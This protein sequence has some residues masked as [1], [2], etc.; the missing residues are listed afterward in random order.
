MTKPEDPNR[1]VI[2]DTTLRD[3]EQSPG[4]SM[5]LA[6]KLKLAGALA[7]LGVDVIEAGFAAASPDDFEA[8]KAIADSIQGPAICALARCHDGDIDQAG[9]ALAG[10]ERRRIHV[11]IATSP[12]HREHKL[13]L[14]KEQIIARAV[15]GIRRA[16]TWTDDVE[17][18]AEDALRTEPEFLA[19]VVEAAID[20]GASTVNI[21][22]TVGY[23]SP[24]EM[25][26]RIRYLKLHV[27]NIDKAVISA[28]C[29]N[30]LGMAVANSL[31]AVAAGARQVEC[32]L[33]GIGE[34][35]GNAAL[36]EVVM[37]LKTRADHYGCHTGINSRRLL[38]ACRQLASVIGQA[39]PRNKAIVGDNAFAHESGI[40][41]H[42]MLQ[43]RDTYEIMDPAD[44]GLVRS[45][46]VLGKHSGRHALADRLRA[47]GHSPDAAR[48]DE[49]FARFKA[50]A[51][52]KRQIYDADIEALL[53]GQEQDQG[54]WQ[55]ARLQIQSGINPAMASAAVI[56]VGPD[57]RHHCEAATG[58]GPVDAAFKAIE[59]ATAITVDLQ[60]FSIRALTG[61]EDAQGEAH[62]Q[63]DID[64]RSYG[65][66]A[67]D[68][69]IIAASAQAFMTIINAIARRQPSLAKAG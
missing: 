4:C 29:H 21:P 20:A 17:F 33:T 58:D 22:D 19:Q 63:A 2:F 53:A 65:G 44:I 57:G 31:A 28:H 18:S 47:L 56:L 10:A 52:R 55:L 64:G 25:A 69:D 15:A 61:G 34:R 30:D 50:L 24:T 39:I 27:A 32:T 68:T 7:E 60:R 26:E 48:L 38:P 66:S 3:G 49:L 9:R 16:R 62:I 54:P 37:A 12:C 40:H 45:E 67:T 23:T 35:A 51:D 14:D 5:T 1:V 6:Q 43:S 13:K 42:G 41:Q 46:L 59:R 36:E 8:V 11:F